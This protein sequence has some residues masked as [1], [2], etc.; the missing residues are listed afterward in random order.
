MSEDTS[1][2][3]PLGSSPTVAPKHYTVAASSDG[4]D[5]EERED[6]SSLEESLGSLENVSEGY[7]D[8]EESLEDEEFVE[9]EESLEE[10]NYLEEDDYLDEKT[11][12][13]RETFLFK[14]AFVEEE[15]YLKEK[16]FQKHMAKE[17]KAVGAA[18]GQASLKARSPV[19][20]NVQEISLLPATPSGSDHDLKFTTSSYYSLSGAGVSL[21]DQSSQTEWPY[22]QSK[23]G[24]PLRSTTI[25]DQD[26]SFV[27]THKKSDLEASETFPQ[28]SFWDTIM[29][30][31]FDKQDEE[32]FDSLPST[33]QSVFR[34][35][36]REL[37]SQHEL[38][39]EDVDMPLSKLL[40]GENRKKLGLLLKKNFEKY[41]E[42][43][44]WI[45]NNREGQ[46]MH[47]ESTTT[48]TYLISTLQQPQKPEAEEIRRHVSTIKKTLKLDAEWIQA[49]MKVHQ[50]D[51]K[52]ITYR[53]GNTFHILFPNGTGQI[54]Y[55]SGN[56]A[57]LIACKGVSRVTYIVLEDCVERKIRGFV[58]NSGHATFYN[59]DGE[60]WLSL[61]KLLGYYF[62]EGWHQKAWNWWN[63]SFHVHAPPVM[64]IT[65]KLNKYVHIQI[66]SQDKV[67]FC[68]FVPKRRRICINM[69]TR[70]KFINLKL[71]Q[72]MKKKAVLE[73]EPGPTSWKIQALLGKI[74]RGLNFLSLS[75]LEHLIE[76]VQEAL[77]NLSARKS[78]IWL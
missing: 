1:S 4:E 77:S 74:S 35:I 29:N 47:E 34:E 39:P 43:I 76:V 48:I 33:Y 19:P 28:G 22:Y 24:T 65:L 11:F 44:M 62:P 13:Q 21:R 72:A 68:F 6:E 50:G 61:S 63:L 38:E 60:I 23:M 71:L 73:T 59:E 51:G 67:I 18:A 54:Y 37:A 58:T 32:S 30:G 46:K 56:L 16:Q 25:L 75:D 15:T 41:K 69:G 14:G 20:N 36:L 5:S 9:E 55:P 49:K 31:P 8:N 66:R 52:I 27:L 17:L 26:S 64:C 3:E 78:R 12:L 42:A 2:S 10:G 7:M 53:S 40:E 70:F 57:L 45:I